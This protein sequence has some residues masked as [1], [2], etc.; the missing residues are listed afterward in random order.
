MSMAENNFCPDPLTVNKS[1]EKDEST[2]ID[3]GYTWTIA[4]KLSKKL[5]YM[6]VSTWVSHDTGGPIKVECEYKTLDGSVREITTSLEGCKAL[7]H[8]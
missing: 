3:S 8:V 4:A 1:I 6:H 5:V 2:F 7:S